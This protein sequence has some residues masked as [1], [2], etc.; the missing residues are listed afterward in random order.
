MLTFSQIPSLNKRWTGHMQLRHTLTSKKCHLSS[1]DNARLLVNVRSPPVLTHNNSKESSSKST[2][3]YSSI[4]K[5]KAPSPLRMIVSGTA[6]TG[7]SYLIH[8]LRLLLGDKV[9]VAAPT[10]VAAFNIEGHT[11][12]SLLSLPTKGEYKDLEG[13]RLHHMQQ[14]LA[15][16]HY[17]IIDE[18]SMVGRKMFGQLD[19]RLRQVFPHHVDQLFWRLLLLAVWRL[20]STTASDGSPFIHNSVTNCSI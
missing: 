14:S 11:L 12:H 9:R 10:G 7:K 6:G 8:C 2:L 1:P 15:G 17:L 3:L 4:W 18:M 20:W 19:K 13:E 5:L 16:M